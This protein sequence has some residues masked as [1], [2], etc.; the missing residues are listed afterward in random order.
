MFYQC[1]Y[2]P[3]QQPHQSQSI[4]FFLNHPSFLCS[5]ITLTKIHSH[6]IPP[7]S[8]P[9]FAR[10]HSSPSTKRISLP[11]PWN[12]LWMTTPRQPSFLGDACWCVDHGCSW[13][14]LGRG[15]N[16]LMTIQS[17]MKC[18]Q[19]PT[20]FTKHALHTKGDHHTYTIIHSI[21]MYR[22]N[23]PVTSP[24]VFRNPRCW[25]MA[26]WVRRWLVAAFLK[27]FHSRC[28]QKIVAFFCSILV[29]N[30]KI[31]GLEYGLLFGVKFVYF[32]Q[33]LKHLYST[34]I[35]T[36][37]THILT[38]LSLSLFRNIGASKICST[39]SLWSK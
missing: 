39:S 26:I 11:T 3:Q 30:H 22:S 15:K 4:V 31:Q 16:H 29:K 5:T 13:D 14:D 10:W 37:D 17:L 32:K 24:T 8:S 18:L 19:N 2:H 20:T 28:F 7:W 6:P 27:W 35:Q 36:C 23:F 33:C 9:V 25:L 1:V 34:Q 38:N 21:C 12:S